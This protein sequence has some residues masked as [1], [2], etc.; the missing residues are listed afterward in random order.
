[1]NP[2]DLKALKKEHI[3]LKD[4]DFDDEALEH[5]LQFSPTPLHDLAFRLIR[6][7]GIR[8]HELLSLTVNH[9]TATKE[10]WASVELPETNPTTTS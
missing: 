10:G 4:C 7:R 2:K 1:M 9:V 3:P 5:L 6:E 8:P